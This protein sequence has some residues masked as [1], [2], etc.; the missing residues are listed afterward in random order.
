VPRRDGR[1]THECR[2]GTLGAPISWQLRAPMSTTPGRLG[3]P[4]VP[5]VDAQRVPL[6]EA[7]SITDAWST[8]ERHSQTLRAPVGATQ[9]CSGHECHS[10]T[11]GARASITDVRTDAWSIRECRSPG[12][13]EN[14]E[15]FHQRRAW[16]Q[17]APLP[18]TGLF[19][20]SSRGRAA[21]TYH[22]SPG[23][24]SQATYPMSSALQIRNNVGA[25]MHI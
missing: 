10:R 4:W 20:S 7:G 21:G 9:G 17:T 2:A 5:L 8:L 24:F 6:M 1:S 12:R 25:H 23:C 11:L 14:V 18:L 19:R 16:Q 13:S 15:L 3:H 22:E